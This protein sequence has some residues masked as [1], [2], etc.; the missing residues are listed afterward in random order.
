MHYF[1]IIN[2][3]GYIVRNIFATIKI[4]YNSFNNGKLASWL[5]QTTNQGEPDE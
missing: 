5:I 1:L 2:I 3:L 4:L